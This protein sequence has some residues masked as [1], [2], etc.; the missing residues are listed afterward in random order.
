MTARGK[1]GTSTS[2]GTPVLVKR[3]GRSRP[4]HHS[5]NHFPRRPM[6]G[7]YDLTPVHCV[8]T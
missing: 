3:I 8:D 5:S 1:D 6:R 7:L 2:S 4:F